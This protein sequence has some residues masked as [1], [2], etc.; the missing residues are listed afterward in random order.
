M[1]AERFDVTGVDISGVQIS[2]AQRLVPTGTFLRADIASL[3][4]PPASFDAVVSF[5]AL[6]HVPVEE[7]RG[8]YAVTA[9][10]IQHLC[11][12]SESG[13]KMSLEPQ[14]V[15][16]V[17]RPDIVTVGVRDAIVTPTDEALGIIRRQRL[18]HLQIVGRCSDR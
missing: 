4:F 7:Q 11:R 3:E 8:M 14:R 12:R 2:R 13:E 6:I 17:T 18:V 15:V 10:K 5:F 16:R 1:L 9:A